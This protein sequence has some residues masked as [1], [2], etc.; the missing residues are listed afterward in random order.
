[1]AGTGFCIDDTGRSLAAVIA[2]K[3]N[4]TTMTTFAKCFYEAHVQQSANFSQSAGNLV[5]LFE[6]FLEQ[7][8]YSGFGICADIGLFL[9]Q[10]VE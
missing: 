9:C 4:L 1:M 10:N 7:S 6:N 5:I 3:D 8:G 2:E